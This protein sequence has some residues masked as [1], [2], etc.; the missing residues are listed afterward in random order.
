MV[1]EK[2]VILG[3]QV[4]GQVLNDMWSFGLNTL[5]TKA[6][7]EFIEPVGGEVPAKRT[8]HVCVT[9][10]DRILIFGGTDGQYH[11]NDTWA[12]HFPTRR[13]S[14]LSCRGFIPTP[15]EGHAAALVGDVMYIFG[16]RGADRKHLSDLCALKL[17]IQ[18]INGKIR[19]NQKW[20][21]F[22]NLGPTPSGRSGHAMAS[23]GSRVYVLGGESSPSPKVDDPGIVH[24]LNTR[25]FPRLCLRP[26]QASD[27]YKN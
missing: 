4:E 10:G 22:Q 3:G 19:T 24:F 13:W 27:I 12:F 9:Y 14:E 21:M 23:V 1:G 5:R 20:Y 16:G 6:T 2:L 8:G 26:A 15:R 18:L 11:Y 17:S 7:W 25:Q